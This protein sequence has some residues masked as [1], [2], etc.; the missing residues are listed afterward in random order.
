MAT[1][2]KRWTE[3]SSIVLKSARWVQRSSIA[4]HE[5]DQIVGEPSSNSIKLDPNSKKKGG[6]FIEKFIKA[7]RSPKYIKIVNS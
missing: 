5:K 6:G 3:Q 4:M 7:I 2:S 1:L